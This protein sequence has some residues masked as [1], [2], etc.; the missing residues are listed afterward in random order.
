MR[1]FVRERSI[2]LLILLVAVSLFATW[3]YVYATDFPANA[4]QWNYSQV[5]KQYLHDGAT[6]NVSSTAYEAVSLHEQIFVVSINS[7][8][9]TI[10]PQWQYDTAAGTWIDG[11][12][13]TASGV[14]A[15]PLVGAD[16]VRATISGCSGCDVDVMFYGYRR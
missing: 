5:F 9:A 2:F 3:E 7:G 15:Y 13:I 11:N 4:G 8:T 1:E 6:S 14:Y 16:T 12:A 10:T